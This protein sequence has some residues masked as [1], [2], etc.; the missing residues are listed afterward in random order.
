MNLIEKIESEH[1]KKDIPTFKSGDTIK[2]HIILKTGKKK[3]GGKD[4][5]QIFQGVV[6]RVKGG[7]INRTFTVKKISY[8][9]GVERIFMINSPIIK[10]IE[11]VSRGKVRRS[12]LYYFRKLRGKAARIKEANR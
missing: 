4:R 1:L 5:V 11:V 3:E 10:K 12:K 8:G 9:V 2:V 6:I 7:G